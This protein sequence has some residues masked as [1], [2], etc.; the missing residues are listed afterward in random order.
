MIY[1]T[2]VIIL[3]L[4]VIYSQSWHL[5]PTFIPP[6][7]TPWFVA[8]FIRPIPLSLPSFGTI[9]PPRL[10]AICLH[11]G[12]SWWRSLLACWVL[13]RS[14]MYHRFWLSLI[15]LLSVAS[16]FKYFLVP[17]FLIDCAALFCVAFLGHARLKKMVILFV[18]F[19]FLAVL[20][21]VWF[22]GG[23]FGSW[24]IA[25]YKTGS[26][27]QLGSV[28]F[29]YLFAEYSGNLFEYLF[30]IIQLI[31][32]LKIGNFY[33]LDFA[34]SLWRIYLICSVLAVWGDWN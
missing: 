6:I 34:K 14:R 13:A 7:H 24:W 21:S 22:S 12:L 30:L 5:I 3:A 25:V 9:S 1:I 8:V 16:I 32:F 20:D 33:F 29:T 27:H 28:I 31:I 11:L 18:P 15:L 10:R 4:H 2:K 26:I 17:S 19:I 23:V